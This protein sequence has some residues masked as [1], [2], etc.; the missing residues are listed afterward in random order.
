MHRP[1]QAARA[2]LHA[3]DRRPHPFSA[4]LPTP[5]APPSLNIS[6]HTVPRG[7]GLP[8]CPPSCL[9]PPLPSPHDCT[10]KINACPHRTL[11]ISAQAAPTRLGM[12]Q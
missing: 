5:T 4:L 2:R 8:A 7:L 6:T 12:P 9:P 10:L 1:H 3:R 11:G